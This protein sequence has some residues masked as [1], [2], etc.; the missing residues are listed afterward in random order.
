MPVGNIASLL[1]QIDR[2]LGVTIV[3]GSSVAASIG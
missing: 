2:R 1:M 3:N